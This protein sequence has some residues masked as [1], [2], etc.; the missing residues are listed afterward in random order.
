MSRYLGAINNK[1]GF[2]L[3][4]MIV[5]SG[6]LLVLIIIAG[7]LIAVSFNVTTKN[8]RLDQ[9][10]QIGIA[11]YNFYQ[12]S[13]QDAKMMVLVPEGMSP[14]AAMDDV[15]ED[16]MAVKIIDGELMIKDAGSMSFTS[17]YG[18]KFYAGLTVDSALYIEDKLMYWQVEIADKE[19][20]LFTRQGSFRLY[21]LAYMDQEVQSIDILK[22][23]LIAADD[24]GTEAAPL[25]NPVIYFLP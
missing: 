17:F 21:Q 12:E 11:V 15:F 7:G 22:L 14:P 23:E 6:L 25:V 8:M 13:L 4:E 9:S 19:K 1:K 3:V 5:V 16:L 10:K 24:L 2:T 20:I 18:E